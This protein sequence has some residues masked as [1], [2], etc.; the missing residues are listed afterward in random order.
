[1]KSLKMNKKYI[2]KDADSTDPPVKGRCGPDG[3][4]KT[5]RP[6]LV[7]IPVFF[8]IKFAIM[9]FPAINYIIVQKMNGHL[10]VIS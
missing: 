4:K 10:F 8:L 3:L 7:S 1:M 2:P 5:G 9:T 6:H